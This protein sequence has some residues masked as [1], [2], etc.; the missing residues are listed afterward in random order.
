MIFTFQVVQKKYLCR[1]KKKNKCGKNVHFKSRRWVVVF[2][3]QFFTSS[4]YSQTHGV[5]STWELPILCGSTQ[6]FS[7]AGDRL[8]APS[9]GPLEAPAAAT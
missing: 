5:S 7:A 2:I 9:A 6:Q 3:K 1:E 4:F 8:H